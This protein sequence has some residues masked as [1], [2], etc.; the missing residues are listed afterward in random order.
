MKLFGG[1][2][3]ATG[4]VDIGGT[5]IAVGIVDA[6]GQVL[7]KDE[8]P[9]A[10]R[11]GFAAAMAR[12]TALLR[13][14]EGSAG[15]RISG[16][17]VGSAGPINPFTGEVG[18]VENLP[19]WQGCN[20]V[21]ALSNALGVKVVLENDADAWTVGEVWLGAGRGK[22]NVLCV[23]VGTGIGVGVWLNGNI[24]RGVCGAHPEIGYQVIDI[25][26]TASSTG[27]KGCWETLACGPAIA[28]E[29]LRI[30]PQHP[31]RDGVTARKV[32]DLARQGDPAAV[33]VVEREGHLLGIG[34]A[35]LVNI[36]CP[37]AVVLGG[38]VMKNADLFL[39]AIQAVVRQY[40][41]Y[42]PFEHTEIVLAGLGSDA[43]LI[44]A[45]MIW[46]QR[47]GKIE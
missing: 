45:G 6:E 42:V 35:N 37:E 28:Q 33:A 17:G 1:R 47:Y 24:F 14:L 39:P 13:R 26:G 32:C 18:N 7:A 10:P 43:P 36:F 27:A 12:V 3:A 31:A 15:V 20:I 40:C 9:T 19:G 21:E 44:G 8:T 25:N 4:A 2:P 23:T 34:I 29:F 22:S 30:A 16:I 38:S 41:T 11:D 46:R 5:K